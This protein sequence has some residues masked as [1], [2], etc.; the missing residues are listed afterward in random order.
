M[1]FTYAVVLTGSIATGK[2]SVAKIFKAFDFT[3]IDADSIAHQLLDRHAQEIIKL[4]GEHVQ[5]GKVIDRQAL[6]S[7]VFQDIQK[8]TA[9]EA[10]LHPLIYDEITRLATLEDK[11]KKPYLV[12]IPLFFETNRYPIK[13]VL[14]VYTPKSLQLQRLMQRNGCSED[15]AQSRIAMQIDIE[16][17][18][19]KATYLIDNSYDIEHLQE[20]CDKIREQIVGDFQ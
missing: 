7:I 11:K 17:K 1:A 3:I 14:V 16:E 18:K 15:E 10:L 2:S 19:Q 20:E 13:K 12:D 4:F 8:R 5:K 6:G 9:L